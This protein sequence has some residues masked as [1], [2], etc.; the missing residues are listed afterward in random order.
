M[1]GSIF[2]L[3]LKFENVI[4]LLLLCLSNLEYKTI[5]LCCHKMSPSKCYSGRFFY[6]NTFLDS[7]FFWILTRTSFMGHTV[8]INGYELINLLLL[9]LSNL[10]YM[11]ILQCSQK[12]S[13]SKCYSRRF[14]YYNI[15]LDSVFFLDSDQDQFSGTYGIYISKDYIL[16]YLRNLILNSTLWEYSLF[17][18]ILAK[19]FWD[20]LPPSGIVQNCMHCSTSLYFLP[21]SLSS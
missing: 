6:Y 15:F 7:V 21:L 16:C 2:L 20:T 1:Y 5:F 17:G 4:N 14:F 13:P 8:D 10:E 19:V 18:S 12:Q 11:T 3:P 9:C